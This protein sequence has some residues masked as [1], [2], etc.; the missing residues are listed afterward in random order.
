METRAHHV[1]IGAFTI[2]AFVLALAFVLWMSKTGVDQ[3][4]ADYDIVFTEAVSGLSVGGLVQYNGIKV[5]EVR[6]LHLAADDPRKVVARVRL[7]AAAP[8]KEDTRAKLALQGV[9]GLSFIQLSGGAPGSPPLLPTREHPVPVIPSEE[10]ALSKLLASGSDIVVTANDLLLRM[11]EILSADNVDRISA[12]LEHLDALSGALAEQRGDIATA[13]H[14]LAEATAA[15]KK[16]LATIDTV[17]NSTNALVRDDA[18]KLIQT[19]DAALASV[20]KMAESAGLLVDDNRAA[21][22]AFSNQGLRQIGPTV[23]EL[24]ETLRSLKQLS[25]KLGASDSLLLGRDQPKE[26]QPQ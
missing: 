26:F 4:Y 17:A 14:Q 12:T 15:M 18:R 1:L 19:A 16:T 9:T 5:G 11:G 8:V 23:L 25:D 13:V 22:G 3:R 21:I 20:N 6:E 10:S 2:G 24:R 7:D